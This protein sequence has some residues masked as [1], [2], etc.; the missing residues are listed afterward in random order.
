MFKDKNQYS[1]FTKKNYNTIL[2]KYLK[3]DMKC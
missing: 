2:K 3:M 1:I